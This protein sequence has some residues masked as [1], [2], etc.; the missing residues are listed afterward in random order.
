M[1]IMSELDKANI[2]CF[3]AAYLPTLSAFWVLYFGYT[4]PYYIMGVPALVVGLYCLIRRSVFL[5]SSGKRFA[6]AKK[7]IA[8]IILTVAL[9]SLSMIFTTGK[10]VETPTGLTIGQSGNLLGAILFLILFL[11]QFS[12]VVSTNRLVGKA[13][14]E[15]R[16][17][18][19]KDNG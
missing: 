10:M 16:A 5:F 9:V 14:K 4:L 19:K 11:V 13:N 12:F 17:N 18:L 6:S 8:D 2:Y 7:T 3:G 15:A 1:K